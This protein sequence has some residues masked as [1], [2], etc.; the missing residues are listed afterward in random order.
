M[1]LASCLQTVS[2]GLFVEV[3][4]GPRVGASVSGSCACAS[5]CEERAAEQ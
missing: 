2:K 4:L 1:P 5:R 3:S